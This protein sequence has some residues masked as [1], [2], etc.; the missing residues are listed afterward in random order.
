MVSHRTLRDNSLEDL[1]ETRTGYREVAVL[2]KNNFEGFFKLAVPKIIAST[3]MDRDWH[4]DATDGIKVYEF[5]RI[6]QD[7]QTY[8]MLHFVMNVKEHDP[9]QRRRAP[10]TG[11]TTAMEAYETVVRQL[12]STPETVV[13]QADVDTTAL[14][15]S[16]DRISSRRKKYRGE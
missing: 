9:P 13:T 5:E 2:E 1:L 3:L 16:L 14:Q 7:N 12:F 4:V 6:T 15:K 11:S 8:K 10:G